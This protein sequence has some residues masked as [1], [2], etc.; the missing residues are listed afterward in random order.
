MGYTDAAATATLTIS[1]I[2]FCVYGAE[3]VYKCPGAWMISFQFWCAFSC[4]RIYKCYRLVCFLPPFLLLFT[5]SLVRALASRPSFNSFSIPKPIYR[6]LCLC[7]LIP[8]ARTRSTRAGVLSE[9]EV[10]FGGLV[11]NFIKIR[12]RASRTVLVFNI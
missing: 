5:H 9:S 6:V 2:Y 12:S 7:M 1:T 3:H 10:Q 4:E 8:H 11:L